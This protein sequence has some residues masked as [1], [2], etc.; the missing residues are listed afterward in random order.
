MT[1]FDNARVSGCDMCPVI[2][3][4]YQ[5]E[6]DPGGVFPRDPERDMSESCQYSVHNL[7]GMYSCVKYMDL[8][9]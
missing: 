5:Q 2:L 8:L 7:H 3:D 9:Y 1:C 6:Q 4:H